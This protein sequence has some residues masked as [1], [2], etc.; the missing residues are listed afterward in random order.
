MRTISTLL[1]FIG[2]S[3]ATQAQTEEAVTLTLE[4]EITEFDKGSIRLALYD[5]EENYMKTPFRTASASVQNKT[6]TLVIDD[7]P[8][9]IYNFSYYHDVDGNDELDKNMMG[10]PKEPYG[11][12]NGEKGNFGPPSFD[13]SKIEISSNTTIQLKIK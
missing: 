8:K 4:F 12:S 3:F 13:N 5:S 10:I 1:L 11:F 6:A 2:L 7:I 9:G